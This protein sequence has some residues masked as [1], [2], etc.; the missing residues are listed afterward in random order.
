MSDCILLGPPRYEELMAEGVRTLEQAGYRCIPNTSGA[1]LTMESI[2]AYADECVAV[3][4]GAEPWGAAQ[5]DL[6][7]RLEIVAK[8]GVGLDTVDLVAAERRGIVVTNT[9]GAN[10]NAVAELAVALMLAAL[11]GVVPAG[12]AL[13]DGRRIHVIGRELAG[14]SVGLVGW[15]NIAKLV[16]KRL[17]G[18]EV[19]LRV[20]DPYIGPTDSPGVDFA[21]S[22]E[23]LVSA[24]DIVSLHLP[25]TEQTRGLVGADLLAS[26]RPGSVLINTARGGL[27]DEAALAEALDRGHLAGAAL[28]V[29]QDERP[30]APNEVRGRENVV[31]LPH[32]GAE[33]Q[34][35]FDAV[36][37]FN[38]EDILATL[39]G[40]TPPRRVVAAP[41]RAEPA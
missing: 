30:G 29:Q 7:P 31:L 19:E 21:S 18:F 10:S 28:D 23:E 17:Q 8:C 26:F 1:P 39:S 6:L 38:A 12:S 14:R 4:A 2:A 3:I 16:A 33:S 40:A 20:F 25:L 32:L 22:L 13:Q 27:V 41:N 37:A 11:R 34:E 15:G 5:L 36:G 24:S 35:A 9:P